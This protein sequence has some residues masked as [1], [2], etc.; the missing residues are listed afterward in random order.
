MNKKE[1]EAL[2]TDLAILQYTVEQAIERHVG[3]K[4]DELKKLAFNSY[5]LDGDNLNLPHP[6]S[7]FKKEDGAENVIFF[8]YDY[9]REA[10]V[11]LYSGTDIPFKNGLAMHDEKSN[12]FVAVGFPD[13]MAIED[14]ADKTEEIKEKIIYGSYQYDGKSYGFSQN[15]KAFTH[16]EIADA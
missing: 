10:F 11:G 15:E 9:E 7:D 12:Y 6:I 1:R 8:C 2:A 16:Y 4:G 5:E 13:G 3:H 14:C